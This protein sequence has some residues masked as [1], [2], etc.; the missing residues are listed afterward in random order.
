MSLPRRLL[1]PRGI[2]VATRRLLGEARF[3]EKAGEVADWS[4]E[5]DG[6]VA[7]ADLVED[8]ADHLAQH[9]AA[10]STMRSE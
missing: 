1:S 8:A 2:R 10:P 6:A 5:H 7:A 9:E 3:R 4:A